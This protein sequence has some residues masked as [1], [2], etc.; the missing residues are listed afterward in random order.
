MEEIFTMNEARVIKLFLLYPTKLFSARGIAK[1]LKL[2]HPTV[3]PILHKLNNNGV[4]KRVLFQQKGMLSINM[5]WQANREENKYKLI[6]RVNNLGS[7][8]ASKLA[9]YIA[10][11]TMP[12]AIVLFGSYSRG[13]DVEESDIDVLVVSKEKKMDLTHYERKLKRKINVIFE[14]DILKLKKEF[15]NNII[16]GVVIYGYLE[17]FK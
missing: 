17:V 7:L 2:T 1:L 12:N 13:E 15:L 3:L 11:K 8:Y 10:N 14:P 6:K 4:V 16:N 9:E 5:L